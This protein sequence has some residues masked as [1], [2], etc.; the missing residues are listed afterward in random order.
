MKTLWTILTGQGNAEHSIALALGSVRMRS[1]PQN[2]QS[3]RR[4][5]ERK[6]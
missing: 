6:R 2:W 4:E 5:S 3:T 1:G